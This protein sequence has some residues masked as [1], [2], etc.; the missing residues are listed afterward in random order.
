MSEYVPPVDPFLL[1]PEPFEALIGSVGQRMTWMRSHAC[2]CTFTQSINTNGRLSSPGSAQTQCL[3]CFGVGTYWDAPT[4]PASM[5]ISFMHMS[6]SPDEP[7]TLMESSFGIVQTVEPS[8]TIPQKV[9][10]LLPGD[11]A[12]PTLAWLYS[13]TN[14]IFIPVDMLAR[15]SAKLQVGGLQ[16]LP[17]QQNLQIPATGAVTLWDQTTHVV[18][19]PSYV[20]SGATVTVP[21]QPNG[22]VYMV[23]F[24]A[25]PIYVAFRRAGGLPHVRPFGQNTPEPKRF[26][27]QALDFWTRQRGI[28][29]ASVNVGGCEVAIGLLGDG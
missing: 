19:Y 4:L 8:L 27:L 28:Q 7:G 6:P 29:A 20:V 2:P 14:D 9:P 10:Q 22:T 25:A 13:S 5:Y 12:Q 3:T 23:E 16:N 1:P 26:R 11:S 21:G 18:T 24:Q 17:F 15:Y